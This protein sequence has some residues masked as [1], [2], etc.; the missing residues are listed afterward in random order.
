MDNENNNNNNNNNN[1]LEPVKKRK[2]PAPAAN[3]PRLVH[4]DLL[5]ILAC[6]SVVMLHSCAQFWYDLPVQ[7]PNWLAANSYN[8]VSRFG[9]PIF[10]ML[11]G[12]LFLSP[13]KEI[14]LKKLYLHNI[15]RLALL[16][17]IWHI[18]YGLFDCRAYDWSQLTPGDVLLEIYAGRYH[19]WYLPMLIGFY[20]LLPMLRSWISHASQ[21]NLQY[22]LLLFFLFQVGKDT[23]LALRQSDGL[24][25]LW[26]IALPEM[27]CGY[28]GYF[29]LGYYLVTYDI[30][31][32]LKRWV[33]AGGLLGV[34][35]N[36]L[37]GNFLSLRAN[38]PRIAIYDSFGIFTFLMTVSLF[39][40]FTGR[41]SRIHYSPRAAALIREISLA[42]LGVYL[43][44]IGL[45]EYLLPLGFHSMMFPPAL[46]IP[47]FALCCFGMCTV[48]AALLRRI[49][50][51]GRYLC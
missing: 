27:A 19:L 13:Q 46:W 41:M 34:F 20:M 44:H 37:L 17:V 21:K 48:A 1:V 2:T 38:A 18:L 36:I 8:S 33:Y 10:V 25:F 6:F 5:R 24:N 35:A 30:S 14:S 23:S 15:L 43:M 9:V 7:D 22:F 45:I 51:I 12:A 32:K 39:L 28:M 50:L 47:V 29:V 49:P 16:Y 26:S 40:F 4:L 42:T 11:S 3:E 31:Q